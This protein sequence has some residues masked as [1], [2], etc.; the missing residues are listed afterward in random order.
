M[1]F[2]WYFPLHFNHY[3]RQKGKTLDSTQSRDHQTDQQILPETFAPDIDIL[4]TVRSQ[5]TFPQH[6]GIDE[7]FSVVTYVANVMI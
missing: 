7:I 4:L 1:L 2:Y 3:I 6:N 5:I